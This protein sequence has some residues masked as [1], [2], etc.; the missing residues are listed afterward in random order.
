MKKY[1]YYLLLLLPLGLAATACHDDDDDVPDVS[2][3]ATVEGAVVDNNTIYVV[4]GDNLVI[5]AITLDNRT[6]KDGA[7][8]AVTYYLNNVNIGQSLVSPYGLEL[9][10]EGMAAGGY[11]LTAEMPV[12]VVDYPICFGAFSFSIVVVED[13][14]ELPGTAAP[15]TFGGTVRTK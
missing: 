14:S 6:G 5:S 8:G 11:I 7:I 3:Q 12:Y 2:L 10:T 15:A 1:L 9:P 13:A 4:K